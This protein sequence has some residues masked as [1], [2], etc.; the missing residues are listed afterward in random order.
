FAAQHYFKHLLTYLILGIVTMF[1]SIFML[2]GWLN[3]FL[4]LVKAHK[5][6]PTDA[7]LLFLP[8]TCLTFSGILVFSFQKLNFKE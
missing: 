6:T 8:L 5:L 3:W 4:V 2:L 1:M 7:Y